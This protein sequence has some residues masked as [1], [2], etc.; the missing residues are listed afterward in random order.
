MNRKPKPE[1]VPE[2]PS[3]EFSVEQTLDGT[4]S[5]AQKSTEEQV[6]M[7]APVTEI[8]AKETD[9]DRSDINADTIEYTPVPEDDSSL[10]PAIGKGVVPSKFLIDET[11]GL[12]SEG[13]ATVLSGHEGVGGRKGKSLVGSTIGDYRID[14]E[15]GRG[16]MGVVYKAHHLNLRRDVAIKMILGAAAFDAKARSRFDTEARAVA[17]LQHP[18]FVQLFEFGKI[19]ESPYLALEFIDGGTLVDRT[20]DSSLDPL[21]AARIVQ[22]I[23]LAMQ[24][25]HD[26]GLLHR[27]LKP[28]NVLLTRDD[29]PKISDFG[30][31]KELANTDQ[32][33]TKTGTVMGTPSF[34][35]PEQAKGHSAELTG[36][37]D[38]YSLGAILYACLSG[39]PP[40]MSSTAIDTIT[41]VVQNDPVPLRQLSPG[42]PADLET[43]CLRTLQKEPE[44]RYEDC[45]ALAEDL[46]R[47][48]AGEP[49][50]AR[51]IGPL[52]RTWRWCKRNPRV[53]VPSGVAGVFIIA[54]ALISSWAWATTSAQA[55]M[56]A[57]E[58]DNVVKERDE[59]QKQ[60]DEAT[61]QR[62]LANQQ[63]AV[64]EEN[65]E[66]AEKQAQLALQNIQFVVT[67]V[68]TL[69]RT[70]PGMSDLRIKVLDA[71]SEK[72][73]EIDVGLAGGIRGE[74]IPTLMAVRQL[75]AVAFKDLD[76]LEAA[77]T[78]FKKLLAMCRERI[79]LKG[80]NDATRSNL[81]K[82]LL[83]SSVLPRRQGDPQRGMEML[84]EAVALVE[85][86]LEDPQPQEG[87]P[88]E[89]E[90]IELLGAASQNLGLEHLREGKM[91]E[92]ELAFSKALD[93]G[94]R[95]LANIR[96]EDG[97]DQLDDNQKDTKTA[98]KQIS[99]DKSRLALAYIRLRLGKTAEALPL[100]ESAIESRKEIF[101]RRPKMLIMKIELAGH[102]KM[103]G[104]SLVWLR[105]LPE[106][107]PVLREALKLAEE[108]VDADP[109]KPANRRA[110][111]DTLYFL[112][113]LKR[114]EKRPDESLS[115]FERS[116]LIREEL[117]ENSD[118]EKN[119]IALMLAEA[120][121]GNADEAKK[122]SEQLAEAAENNAELHLERARALAAI[123]EQAPEAQREKL[124]TQALEALAL[125]LDQGFADPFR[126]K[127][128]WEFEAL[129][130]N[131]KFKEI[132][133]RIDN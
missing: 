57:A 120:A 27:D 73:D 18:N 20:K 62:I 127:V 103:Y 40:F 42:I 28:A 55:A 65:K 50:L 119:A 19:D 99:L 2:N 46:R 100:Y 124:Q 110:L 77:D 104:K 25:A 74:A 97:Y 30:L 48:I 112:G 80:R 85:E 5:E 109:E 96:G 16:G 82:V 83:A 93:A 15:L 64:A 39:R 53:A 98:A 35:S 45:A 12:S 11:T 133:A 68:D 17:S 117:Y 3:L 111:A 13:G 69:L 67:D 105:R 22:E 70:Q 79:A 94:E 81:A 37:T 59:A 23:A 114:H 33:E 125:S 102:L 61:R 24:A 86:I 123:A 29:V 113:A 26:Q 130:A 58:R 84:E 71:V 56:I 47:F 128:E 89:N 101:D 87:S 43:I 72:W 132:L 63:Q 60:R 14:A 129:Q 44:K 121:V 66:L 107:S 51:P 90:I 41:Q 108:V 34:M 76:K 31:A 92:A 122:L 49:I 88:S 54:T 131:E 115:F 1:P 106:A 32:G 91:A 6:T 95:V 36:A 52:E 118:D 10:Q 38:Q 9:V 126:L 75:M 4:D 78:E 116:R 7:D 21:E 8:N